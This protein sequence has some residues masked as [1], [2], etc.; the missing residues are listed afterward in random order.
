MSL[1]NATYKHFLTQLTIQGSKFREF[2]EW[3]KGAG[4]SYPGN[5]REAA[6]L[7]SGEWE[8]LYSLVCLALL[9]ASGP[10]C[11]SSVVLARKLWRNI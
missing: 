7:L 2:Y 1:S 3:L 11:F 9:T 4:D 5:V 6:K 8:D 10:V